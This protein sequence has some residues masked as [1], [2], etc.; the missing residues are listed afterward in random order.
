M[1]IKTSSEGA[2]GTMLYTLSHEIVHDIRATNPASFENLFEFVVNEYI[3]QGKSADEILRQYELKYKDKDLAREEF[4]ADSM[5]SVLVR[6]FEG[7]TKPMSRLKTKCHDVWLKIR[8]MLTRIAR[9]IVNEYKGLKPDSEAGRFVAQ[10]SDDTFNVLKDMYFD[11]MGKAAESRQHFHGLD[12]LVA[13]LD[14]HNISYD[15]TDLEHYKTKNTANNDG[16]RNSI[17]YTI[18]G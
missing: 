14:E 9:T 15:A 12:E 13:F 16:V 11:A 7:D 3:R 1:Y 6:A 5:E 10:L 4:V 17:R 8:E 18:K 2:K